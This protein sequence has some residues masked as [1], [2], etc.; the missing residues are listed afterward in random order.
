MSIKESREPGGVNRSSAVRFMVLVFIIIGTFLLFQLT[1]IGQYF[2]QASIRNTVESIR[3]FESRFG[4]FGPVL[5]WLLGSIAIVVNIPSI[6]IIWFAVMTYG[7]VVG[8]IE[9]T[10][11]INTASLAIYG[12]SRGLGRDFVY[13]VFGKR[14]AAV[15]DRFERGGFITVVYLRLIFFMLPP[16]NWFLGLM[17]LKFRD[18]FFGT[19]FGTLHNIIIN[20]WIAGVGIRIIE[21][22]RSLL[23]WKSPEL[24]PPLAVGLAIFVAVRIFDKRRQRQKQGVSSS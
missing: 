2:T 11:C 4:V 12:I 10:I 3:S 5:F 14:L 15:E 20:A 18:F 19:M 22:G 9:S 8:A 13:K 23:F 6:L 16:L 17:N 24:A 7:P 21:E 1:D